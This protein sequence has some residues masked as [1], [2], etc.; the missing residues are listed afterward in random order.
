MTVVVFNHNHNENAIYLMNLFS[1][2][3]KVV[4]LDSGSKNCPEQFTQYG[5]IFYSGLFNEAAKLGDDIM[6]ITS[7]V[8]IDEENYDKLVGKLKTLENVG[9][10]S[11]S[12]TNHSRCHD[13]LRKKGSGLRDV[14]FVEGFFSLIKKDVLEKIAPIDVSINKLGWG[15]DI[16]TGFYCSQLGL[17]C[18][19]DDDVQITHPAG[20]GYEMYEASTQ[21][22]D[23]FKTVPGISEYIKG[24][25]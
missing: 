7:D 8:S 25:A 17:R 16:A 23:Y 22:Y 12:L 20:T 24:I 9:C 11:P 2:R 13:F 4:V 14:K 21:M 19:V 15:I 1:R 3:L 6:I 18:V 10:Y 5:N